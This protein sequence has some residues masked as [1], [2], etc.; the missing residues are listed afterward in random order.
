MINLFPNNMELVAPLIFL[1][2]VLSNQIC[3]KNVTVPQTNQ[4]VFPSYGFPFPLS[5]AY[6]GRNSNY[7]GPKERDYSA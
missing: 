7:F 2:I 4:H 5:L 3:L 1:L 6:V